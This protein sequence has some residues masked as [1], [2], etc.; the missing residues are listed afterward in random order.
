[1][2]FIDKDGKQVPNT[3]YETISSQTV[4]SSKVCKLLATSR[5]TERTLYG[6]LHKLAMCVS[7][8]LVHL[9]LKAT[10]VVENDVQIQAELK[11]KLWTIHPKSDKQF[12]DFIRTNFKELKDLALILIVYWK[13]DCFVNKSYQ[14]IFNIDGY[15]FAVN[16]INSNFEVVW[17]NYKCDI[18]YKCSYSGYGVCAQWSRFGTCSTKTHFGN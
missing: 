14:L 10:E 18:Q 5:A 17:M 15:G 1:M 4:C 2:I 9:H 6:F 7:Q 8:W 3:Q 13:K 16:I 12:K 11:D